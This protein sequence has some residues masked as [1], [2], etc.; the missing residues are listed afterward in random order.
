MRHG[1][2]VLGGAFGPGKGVFLSKEGSWAQW[3]RR[4]QGALGPP[5]VTAPSL[6]W[7]GQ[8]S[9]NS[10]GWLPLLHAHP[11]AM[12]PSIHGGASCTWPTWTLTEL[13]PCFCLPPPPEGDASDGSRLPVVSVTAAE[14]KA[15]LSVQ[16]HC[17][18]G[19]RQGIRAKT[20][21]CTRL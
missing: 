7:P 4:P 13:S 16:C 1:H 20:N 19:L 15:A 12:R 11:S 21:G 6:A 14:P 5:A 3:L 8:D 9:R 17:S 10:A 18:C 2:L